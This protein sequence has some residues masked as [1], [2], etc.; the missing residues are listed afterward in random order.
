MQAINNAVRLLMQASIFLLKEFNDWE[1]FTPKSYPALKTFIVVVYTRCILVQQLRNTARQQGYMPTSHNMYNVFADKDNTDTTAT[2]TTNIAAL[3]TGSTITATIPELVASAINN[4]LSA[5]QTALMN[6]I[7]AILY[8]NVP[9]PPSKPKV[10]T[11][12]PATHHSSA[13]AFC[14]GLIRRVQPWKWRRWQGGGCS[15]QGQGRRGGGHNQ[16]T[17]FA[18]FGC[19]KG[20]RDIGQGCGGGRIPQAPGTFHPHAPTFVTSNAWNIA[21][22]FSNTVKSYANWNFVILAGLT[23]KAGTRP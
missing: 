5:N 14:Q 15:R 3:K 16:G 6:Q 4:Q 9:P 23:W 8:P 12:N 1:G 22:P 20:G 7:A 10:P 17:L 13:A 11:T 21:M 18:N 19:N 2:A